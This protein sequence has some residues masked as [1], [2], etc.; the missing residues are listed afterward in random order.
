MNLDE[1]HWSQ[2]EFLCMIALG[3]NGCSWNEMEKEGEREYELKSM[4]INWNQ[5]LVLNRIPVQV[6]PC[7]HYR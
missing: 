4:N 5:W 6:I 7:L 2:I 3:M 1:S